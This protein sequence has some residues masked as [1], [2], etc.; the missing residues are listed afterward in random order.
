M[1]GIG[2]VS[3]DSDELFLSIERDNPFAA[4][5]RKRFFSEI[6]SLRA[7]QHPHDDLPG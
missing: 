2:L 3:G 7:R 5:V 6:D 4:E 1:Q